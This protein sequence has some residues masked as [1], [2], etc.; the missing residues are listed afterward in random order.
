MLQM[1]R[2]DNAFS[3]VFCQGGD[4]DSNTT[5]TNLADKSFIRPFH[6]QHFL[7]F[8]FHTNQTK[9]HFLNFSSIFSLGIKNS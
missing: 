3:S 4:C 8:S 9:I 2:S 1:E 6:L 7:L 5:L